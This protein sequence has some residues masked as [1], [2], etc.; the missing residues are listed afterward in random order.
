MNYR[1]QLGMSGPS[2]LNSIYSHLLL[3]VQAPCV[4]MH[5]LINRS[6]F[7]LFKIMIYHVKYFV[8]V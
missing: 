7:F 1:I 3:K 5:S 4:S 2:N 6:P 8:H